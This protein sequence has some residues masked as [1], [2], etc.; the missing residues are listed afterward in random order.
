M[1]EEQGS[2]RVSTTARPPASV[3]VTPTAAPTPSVTAAPIRAGGE[4]VVQP[5]DTLFA[6]AQRTGVSVNSILVVNNI[7][8]ANRITAG[9]KLRIPGAGE[10]PTPTTVRA[11]VPFVDN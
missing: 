9:Q 2:G 3:V 8:D 1:L 7:T 5:G 6:I 4:Y 11:G 10:V